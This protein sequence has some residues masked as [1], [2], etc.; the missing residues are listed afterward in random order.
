MFDSL[1]ENAIDFLKVSLED[2]KSRPKY[3]VINFCSAV[4]IFFKAR[5]MAE[6]WSLVVV[7]PETATSSTFR[8]GEFKS[9]TLD[10]AISRLE[11]I[12]G[13]RFSKSAK[14]TFTILRE[15]RNKLIHFFHPE[16]V[17]TADQQT[18]TRIV[19][20]QC[21][22]WL[23]LHK[24]LTSQWRQYFGGFNKQIN[25]LDKLMHEHREFLR[26]KYESLKPEIQALLAAGGTIATCFACGFSA[27]QQTE[28]RPPIKDYKCLVCGATDRYLYMPCPACRKD[29]VYAG[30]GDIDCTECGENIT[31]DDVIEK[32]TPEEFQ[33]PLNEP[34]EDFLAY[35][36]YCDHF[37]PSVVKLSN[38]WV[39]LACLE[40]HSE[41][42]RCDWCNEFITGDL[43]S[44]GYFG[45]SHCDG[46]R[47]W[48]GDD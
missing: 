19:S 7:K 39:C 15:H 32:F 12:A 11:N 16:Y 1:A 22:A 46:Q 30:Y 31:V 13:E 42:G 14:D 2:F 21:Q 35:C 6:H 20:E 29:Q 27:A 34:C 23:H 47:G 24:L 3:S 28:D 38:D 43:E 18:I 33:K 8:E 17:S 37:N 44:S 4:E 36:H 41:P 40:P 9:V 10:Q 45:C 26:E 25:E 48:D 5:L